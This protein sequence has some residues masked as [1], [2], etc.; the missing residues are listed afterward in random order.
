MPKI[1]FSVFSYILS[2]KLDSKVMHFLH[3]VN[4]LGYYAVSNTINELTANTT[5]S[6]RCR[7]SN[8]VIVLL[9]RHAAV[10]NERIALHRAT[11]AE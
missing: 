10:V 9:W 7:S 8:D 11:A 5:V 1:S 4:L 3:R 6:Q 2:T